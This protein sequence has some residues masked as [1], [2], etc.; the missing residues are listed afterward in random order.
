MS[1][2]TPQHLSTIRSY[3]RHLSQFPDP[4][5]RAYLLNLLH[6]RCRRPHGSDP[7]RLEKRIEKTKHFI[8]SVR[9][10]IAAANSGHVNVYETLL[11]EAFARVGERRKEFMQPYLEMVPGIAKEDLPYP[12]SEFPTYS[13]ALVA[14]LSCPDAYP[15]R[16]RPS[17][18]DLQSIPPGTLITNTWSDLPPDLQSPAPPKAAHMGMLHEARQINKR[19]WL[20]DRWLA[21]LI[22]P[23]LAVPPELES[24]LP[25]K[26]LEQSRKMLSELKSRAADVG[27]AGSP[28]Y[29]SG[30]KQEPKSTLAKTPRSIPTPLIRIPPQIPKSHPLSPTPV[31]IEYDPLSD[32]LPKRQQHPTPGPPPLDLSRGPRK[33]TKRFLRRRYQNVLSQVP[34]LTHH[35]Q[36]PNQASKIEKKTPLMEDSLDGQSVDR[37][38]MTPSPPS[39]GDQRPSYSVKLAA[40]RLGTIQFL[41]M[42]D[43]DLDWMP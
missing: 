28:R 41:D 12:S 21:G 29:A 5:T 16:G 1:R 6:Q 19:R 13:P 37:N 7:Q 9:L 33:L 30:P 14:L 32:L 8:E 24:S 34:I 35:H 11:K 20:R 2:L 22:G 42:M 25:P 39:D 3:L 4:I 23:P 40:N 17:I 15:G 10:K 43:E 36:K 26:I 18:G 38:W 27:P 31:K